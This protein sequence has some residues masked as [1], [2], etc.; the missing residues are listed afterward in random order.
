MELSTNNKIFSVLELNTA[1]RDLIKSGFSEYIWVCGEVQGLRPDRGKKHTYFELVEKH[2]K[3]D[4]IIAKVKVALFEGRKHT[5]AR[6]IKEAQGA[7]ELKND[8]EVKLLCEVSIHPPTGQYSLIVVDIDTFYTL[9]KAAQMRLKIIEELRAQGMLD[10]NKGLGVALVPLSLGLITARDSAAYHDFINELS[11]S[12]IG[13]KV[14][15][16][17]AHMQGKEVEKDVCE[18]L[19]YFKR[20]KN[21]YDI[22]V[23]TRGGGSKA[24]LSWFDNK[25]IAESVASSSIPVFSALGHHIDVSITDMAA[26]TSVKTPTKAAQ[27]IVEKVKGFAEDIE[28][29]KEKIILSAQ[30]AINQAVKK[31]HYEAVNIN[32]LLPKFFI[33]NRQILQDQLH[34]IDSF[35][36]SFLT[37]NRHAI[38]VYFTRIQTCVDKLFT[39]EKE[40]LTHCD[41]KARL[42]NPHCVIKRGYSLAFK[43]NRVVKSLKQINEGDILKTLLQDGFFLSLVKEKKESENGQ[44]EFLI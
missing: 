8:I 26:H 22:V 18:A 34:K 13:F 17:N 43:D 38:E 21:D 4:E 35:V 24:D 41:E 44:E 1:V 28:N 39:R 36:S 25:K 11:L 40:R 30:G 9:G 6:R 7:F 37:R 12:G 3:A 15:V 29:L 2:P 23:I 32:S 5:I 10:K 14:T 31:L 19:N 20:N 27:L 33:D 42:L 16:F